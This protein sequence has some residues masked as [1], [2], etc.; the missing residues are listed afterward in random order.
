MEQ[1]TPAERATL[2]AAMSVLWQIGWVVGGTWYAVLQAVLGFEGGYTV[3][4]ITIITLYTIATGLYWVWFR[5]A[6]RRT[7]AI[8]RVA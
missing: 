3:N 1:V 8:R 2:S 5:A 4:F 6:D 7:L